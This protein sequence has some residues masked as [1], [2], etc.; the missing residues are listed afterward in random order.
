LRRFVTHMHQ[1]VALAA[2]CRDDTGG[3]VQSLIDAGQRQFAGREVFILEG[4]NDN[5]ALAH[6]VSLI[7]NGE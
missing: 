7:C 6:G 4:D 2:G 3:V 1:Q 5:C